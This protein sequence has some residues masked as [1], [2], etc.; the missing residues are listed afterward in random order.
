MKKDLVRINKSYI[1]LVI[2]GL[3]LAGVFLP[4]TQSKTNIDNIKGFDKGPSYTS[5]VPLKKTTFVNFDKETLLDDYSYLA[6]IPTSV[7]TYDGKLYSYPLLYYED[8]YKYKEDKERSLNAYQGLD[9]FMQDWAEYCNKDFDQITLINVDKG[10][11]S[12]WGSSNNY[13]TIN[14]DDPYIIASEIA[15][16]DWSYSDNAVIA[17]IQDQ[18]EK[19]KDITHGKISGTIQPYDIKTETIPV[20]RPPIGIGAS[21]EDFEI[22]DENYK[23][24]VAKMSWNERADYDLQLYDLNLGMVQA[25]AGL[26]NNPFPYEEVASSYI[27]N[28]EKWR[29]AVSAVPV[30]G[31]SDPFDDLKEMYIVEPS[32]TG[33]FSKT[34]DNIDVDVSLYPGSEVKI[35]STPFGVRDIDF[36]LKWNNPDIQLGMTII[37]PVGIEI[38]STVTPDQIKE[39]IIEGENT[40]VKLH[41]DRLGECL[42]GENYSVCVFALQDVASDLD[43][44]VEYSWRQNFSKIEG[45]CLAS[46]TNGAVLAS[47]LNAPLLYVSPDSLPGLTKDTLYKLGVENIYITNFGNHLSSKVKEELSEIAE[48]VDNYIEPK[49]IYD[50]IRE[51]SGQN[52]IIFSTIDP[53]TYW[54][55]ELDSPT[56]AGTYPGALHIGPA[57]Y[58]AAHHGS[59]VIIV[60]IHPALSQAITWSTDWWYKLSFYRFTEPSAGN[61]KLTS[62]RA[63][64]FLEETGFG[65]IEQATAEEQDH[66]II[67]TVADQFQIGT[68][69]DRCFTGA[70][71]PGRFWGSP[72]DSAY[73]ICRNMFYPALIFVNPGTE[74]VTLQQGSSSSVNE[75]FGRFKDPKGVNLVVHEVGEQEFQYPV[76][77]TYNT[78]QYKYNERGSKHW[79]FIYTQADGVT[80]Y[81]TPSRDEIDDGA[82]ITAA[83]KYYPDQSESEV[84]PFYCTKAGYSNVYSTNFDYACDNLNK[85]VIIWVECCHGM[86]THGGMIGMWNPES[87]YVYEENPWRAYEPVL[88]KPGHVRTYLH[89]LPYS[90]YMLFELVFGKDVSI[91]KTISSLRLIDFQLFPEVACTENPEVAALNPQ[92]IY[93]NKLWKPI[94]STI[95]MHDLWGA[96][97]IFI[98]RD[99]LKEPLKYIKAGLPLINIY[100]GDGKVTCSPTSGA[101]TTQKWKTAVEFDDALQ[102]LHSCGINSLSCLPAVTYLH[103]TW[104]RHGST[105]QI[106]DPWTTTDWAAV[107]MQSLLKRFAMGDTIGEAYEKGMRACGPEYSVPIDGD[108]WDVWENVELF[109]DPNLRVYVPST[110]FSDAN[111]WEKKDTQSL[112]YD[113]ELNIQGHMPFGATS[114]PH[115]KQPEKPFLEKYIWYIAI[116]IIVILIIILIAASRSRKKSKKK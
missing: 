54:Y 104:M 70:A 53:W 10:K 77:H 44:K 60:D 103:L 17:V 88:I 37:D 20:T 89:W 12:N 109:G 38:A 87:P 101:D 81:F 68:P 1:A 91:L 105:Y 36:T 76:L 9:Y 56:P 41:V 95:S 97:G 6:A 67:I 100:D 98:Y 18:Y 25:S 45:D 112:S 13:V 24:V 64:E 55:V 107:W 69:W 73:A 99:R 8:E 3:L 92:L 59:P 115:A 15:L 48:I 34:K 11:V 62:K 113:S 32:T 26:Y 110:E 29:V 47:G 33:L 5:V 82:R 71:Y 16:Q 14:G 108:W 80:P 63:Y 30:K 35:G 57:A 74:T 84:I 94:K 21:T 111:H 22:N 39:G 4:A 93:L 116:I 43:F 46:A 75:S 78:Y 86:Y 61:M 28:Y 106:I 31:S 50:K 96:S 83:G 58:I 114:Y 85:G 42:P 23:Y 66:E 65:K 7:F 49:N 19:P 90:Y 72:V 51:I 27:H 79:N 102:N 40:E 52:D 2:V